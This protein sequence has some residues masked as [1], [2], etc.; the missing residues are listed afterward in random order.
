M[1]PSGSDLCSR[2]CIKARGSSRVMLQGPT[3]STSEYRK[4]K[5]VWEK[6]AWCVRLLNEQGVYE[7]GPPDAHILTAKIPHKPQVYSLI[8]E[9][10]TI[11]NGWMTSKSW[12]FSY[13]RN[14]RKDSQ[15]STA[16]VRGARIG[17]TSALR[18]AWDSTGP[19]RE[20]CNNRELHCIV[21]RPIQRK[22][23]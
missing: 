22:H 15:T 7:S 14:P 20:L 10:W 23:L 2:A 16:Q 4:S 18:G 5:R 21:D 12:K 11:S 9:Q 17:K 19:Q 6:G 8:R 3:V 1:K 13:L